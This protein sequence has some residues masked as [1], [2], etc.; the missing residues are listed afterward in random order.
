MTDSL[1]LSS[2]QAEAIVRV[3]EAAPQVLRRYQFFVWTQNHLQTLLPHQLAVCGVYQRQRREVVFEAFHNVSLPAAVLSLFTDGGSA[4]MRQLSHAWIDGRGR[5]RLLQLS[6]LLADSGQTERDLLCHSGI[7]HLFVH[8]VARP[9]RPA[10]LESLFVFAAPAVGAA[11]RLPQQQ[12]RHLEL[13]LPHLHST[14]L[15]VQTTERELHTPHTRP[16][17]PVQAQAA[18]RSS[19]TDRERQILSWVRE[20]KSNHEIGEV[21]GISPLTVKNHV[22]KILRKLGASN[23]AQAVA[24]AMSQNLLGG[25]ER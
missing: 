15:R 9:Q 5:P 14:W 1:A 7:E 17:P 13:L 22:Q 2:Q 11:N 16:S 4:L 18:V 3:I 23:R 21:L 10:D 24:Q 19:I 25:G 12:L 6:G 20:G 8:G